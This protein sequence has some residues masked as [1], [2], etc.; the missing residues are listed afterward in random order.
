MTFRDSP[1]IF[2]EDYLGDN[3]LEGY[4]DEYGPSGESEE[5]V[6]TEM[7]IRRA[8]DLV[9][10]AKA[11]PLSASVLV[12]REE[13]LDIL[14]GALEILPEEIKQARW[15]LKERDEHLERTKRDALD[16]IDEARAQAARLVERTE[17]VRQAQVTAR[18]IVDNA[19]QE[20]SRLTHEAEDFCDK[21]LAAFEIVLDK[22]TKVVRAGREKLNETLAPVFGQDD[23]S[24]GYGPGGDA[25]IAGHSGGVVGDVFFDQDEP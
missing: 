21:K 5:Q 13:L 7:M 1:D 24:P 22:T 14:V 8:I 3:D 25:D 19:N 15:L 4:E 20:A 12:A 18:T 11:M 10:S 6:D 23:Q 9:S 16:I 17:V 2:E